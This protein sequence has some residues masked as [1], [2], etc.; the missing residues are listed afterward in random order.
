M[1]MSFNLNVIALVLPSMESVKEAQNSFITFNL[2]NC[3]M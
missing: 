2:P 1:C 3:F